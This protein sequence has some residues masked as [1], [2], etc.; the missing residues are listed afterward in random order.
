MVPLLQLLDYKLKVASKCIY[1]HT[2]SIF[3]QIAPPRSKSGILVQIFLIWI[4]WIKLTTLTKSV[5]IDSEELKTLFLIAG[6]H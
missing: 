2:V 4:C 3:N 1:E 5:V 6:E